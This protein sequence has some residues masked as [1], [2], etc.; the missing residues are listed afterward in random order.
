MDSYNLP[1]AVFQLAMYV[2]WIVMSLVQLLSVY[3]TQVK[4]KS[5][6]KRRHN[7]KMQIHLFCRF[8]S[9]ASQIQS[10]W[11]SIPVWRSLSLAKKPPHYIW[12]IIKR[13]NPSISSHHPVR[14]DEASWTRSQTS[15]SS[16]KH[17]FLPKKHSPVAFWGGGE[18]LGDNHDLGNWES[19]CTSTEVQKLPSWEQ[20][21]NHSCALTLE[22]HGVELPGTVAA[23]CMDHISV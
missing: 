14:A 13:T 1:P 11:Y 23:D 19:P 4:L 17:F 15:C 5:R 8:R 20:V 6:L 7:I 10:V 3:K 21:D 18:Y 22:K 9:H 12:C 16:R 2:A